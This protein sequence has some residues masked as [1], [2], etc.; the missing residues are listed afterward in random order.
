MALIEFLS[1]RLTDEEAVIK[2]LKRFWLEAD[3]TLEDYQE[4]A[5]AHCEAKRRII[6]LHPC[7]DCGA[8]DDPCETLRLLALPFDVHP[9]YDER[10]RP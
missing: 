4:R 5:L 2:A 9:D 10:W 3:Y 1:A 7:D 8:G 6:R